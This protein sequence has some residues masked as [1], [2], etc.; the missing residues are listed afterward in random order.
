M[1]IG[2][3]RPS[4]FV[5]SSSEGKKFAIAVQAALQP[6]AEVITWDQGVFAPGKTFIENLIAAL[7]RFDFAILIL[8]PDDLVQSRS[9]EAFGPR[10]NVIFELGLFMGRLGR[11]RT[12][13]LQ[14]SG[15]GLRI[16]T[17][18]SGLTTCSYDWPRDDKNYKAAVAPVSEDI[19]DRIQSLGKRDDSLSDPFYLQRFVDAQRAEFESA[20]FEL[21]NGAKRGHWIWYI[22]PQ[23]A[24]LGKSWNSDFFG[25]SSRAEAEAYLKHPILGQRLRDCTAIVNSLEDCSIKAIFGGID[26]VKFRSSMTLFSEIGPD[27]QIFEQALEKYFSG[28]ADPITLDILRRMEERTE[29]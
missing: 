1:K 9:T 16:P 23:L 18:L 3:T 20:L 5:G 13:I 17:D 4:V 25:I 2:L 27:K 29:S 19:R 7:S 28:A 11:D 12:F 8:T 15:C 6:D 21:Q 14:Q 26:S 10:D 22:F 24:G